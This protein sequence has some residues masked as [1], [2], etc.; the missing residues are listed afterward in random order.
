[1]ANSHIQKVAVLTQYNARSLNEHLSS[2]NGGISEE[3]RAVFCIYSYHYQRN[4]FWYQGTADAI[5]QNLDFLKNSHEPY[6]VIASGD[7]VYKMDYNKVLEYHIAKRADVTV[8]CTTC[9]DPSQV[10]RFGVLRMNEDCR[11][12]EFEEKPMVSS[13]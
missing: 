13:I 1:M 7:C 5:Y 2:P 8:V 4:S 11:I 12:E 9:K 6:V 10:E 3:N